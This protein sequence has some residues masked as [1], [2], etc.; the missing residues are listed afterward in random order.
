MHIPFIQSMIEITNWLNIH[1]NE[2]IITYFDTKWPI[3]SDQSG[4]AIN[5]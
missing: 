1:P 2:F 4:W 5:Y 3:G